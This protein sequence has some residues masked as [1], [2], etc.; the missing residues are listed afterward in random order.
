MIIKGSSK[1]TATHPIEPIFIDRWSA[2]AMSGAPLTPEE[3][4]PLFEAARWAPSA[5]NFQPWRMLYALRDTPHWDTFFNLLKPGNQIWAHRGGALV[6]FIARHTYD[7]GKPCG[8][9][10][11]DTGAA[12]Q[13]FALQAAHDGFAIHGLEGFDYERARIDLA[14]PEAF[15]IEA[16]AVIGHHG[17]KDEL[18]EK[19]QERERPSDRRPLEETVCEGPYSLG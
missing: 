7:T 2:R 5:H 19:L 18:S 15:K 6:M 9:H 10:S 3:L 12:W 17:D 4:M 1:R 11:Y 14:I 8:T 16:M 13:N